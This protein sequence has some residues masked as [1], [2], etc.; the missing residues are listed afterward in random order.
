MSGLD[1]LAAG[2]QWP[3]LVVALIG[4]LPTESWRVLAVWLARDLA[5]D[6]PVLQWVRLVASTLLMAVVVKLVL[7]PSGAMQAVPLWGRLTGI[8]VA[9]GLLMLARVPVVGAVIAGGAVVVTAGW[10]AGI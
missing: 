1:A 4:F 2:P 6:S 10:V 9:L 5:E 3:Y 7:V 8:A